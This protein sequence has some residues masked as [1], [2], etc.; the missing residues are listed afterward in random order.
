M[1][2]QHADTFNHDEDAAA[3]DADV[4][5][6]THPIRAGYEAT[7]NWLIDQARIQPDDVVLDLGSGTGNLSVR[8]PD[9]AELV[10][11]DISAKMTEI[12]REKLKS[13]ANVRFVH[14]DLLEFFHRED[15]RFDAILSTYAVHHLTEDEKLVLF[16][17]VWDHLSPGGLAV[18]GDLMV[19]DGTAFEELKAHFRASGHP[20]VASDMDDEFLW[21][22]E[23]S[24]AALRDL[25]LDVQTERFSELSWGIAARK[26]QSPID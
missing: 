4:R 20:D 2:S 24:A 9:C 6:E 14:A 26:P 5:N 19:A 18:F 23:P 11:V 17:H 3:Y 25:G 12:A 16:Q 10:C 7:L 22:M 8:V 13:R 15:Q 21:W 1:R